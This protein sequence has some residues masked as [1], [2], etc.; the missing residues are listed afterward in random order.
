[1]CSTSV[2]GQ[3][4][5]PSRLRIQAELLVWIHVVQR[6]VNDSSEIDHNDSWVLHSARHTC[7]WYLFD[8]VLILGAIA[9]CIPKV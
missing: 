9:Y 4:D 1:M 2:G 6:L 8:L 3:P 5:F 7:K